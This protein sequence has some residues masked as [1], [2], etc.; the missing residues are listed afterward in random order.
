MNLAQQSSTG[1]ASELCCPFRADSMCGV[2][3]SWGER[4]CKVMFVFCRRS[5]LWPLV[6]VVAPVTFV[7]Y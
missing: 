5:L 2:F 1:S 3:F 6:S 7:L 4:D